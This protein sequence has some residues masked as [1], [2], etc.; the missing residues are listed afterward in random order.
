MSFQNPDP[1]NQDLQRSSARESP[2][3][4]HDKPYNSWN[5]NGKRPLE[6]LGEHGVQD[7]RKLSR[8]DSDDGSE[9][10][11]SQQPPKPIADTLSPNQEQ[12]FVAGPGHIIFTDEQGKRCPA[13]CF[14]K[15][16]VSG[17]LRIEEMRG[18]LKEKRDQ[19]LTAHLE[20]LKI[21]SSNTSADLEIAKRR[22][23]EAIKIRDGI[24]A[25]IPE[26]VEA[27]QQYDKLAEASKWSEFRL[28]MEKDTAN[29]VV[30]R[31]LKSENLLNVP[32]PKPQESAEDHKDHSVKPALVPEHTVKN[33][34]GWNV[35]ENSIASSSKRSQS[36]INQEGNLT[37]RQRALR[38]FRMAVRN[39][40]FRQQQ[41]AYIE[42]YD[43]IE[44][45]NR[46]HWREQ[47]PDRPASATRTDD[48]LISFQE[49]RDLTRLVIEAE[50]AYDL[51]QQQAEDLG[52]GDI[53][54]DPEAF[55]WGEK[56]NDFSSRL[57][58]GTPIFPA[59]Q[60][61]IEAWM[62]SVPDPTMVGSQ[63]QGNDESVEVDDWEAKSI[64][65]FDSIS[66]VARDG[67]RK[68]IDKWRE[69]SLR[70]REGEAE[71]SSPGNLRRNPRRHCRDRPSR[72]GIPRTRT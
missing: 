71:G 62:A 68:K 31:I 13:I 19:E 65:L 26:L 7:P 72:G 42:K 35:S 24:E 17:F 36:M 25:G 47:D 69:L 52:L 39:L 50:E 43:P 67:F 51:A 8:L 1:S 27:R 10:E 18:D 53:L 54:G 37:P 6:D 14:N 12:E 22:V 32:P 2:P 56:C 33:T 23:E 9:R 46:R 41:F 44:A 59:D 61:R 20:F 57:E 28:E 40:D 45:A 34:H 4:T 48:D 70:W 58:P 55:Y 11:E 60:W 63:R 49:K 3:H 16:L 38:H 29:F 15:D 21:K 66:Y 30:E 64:E 5:A